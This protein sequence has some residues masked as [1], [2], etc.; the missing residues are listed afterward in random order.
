LKCLYCD[1]EGER[2]LCDHFN[3]LPSAV[4]CSN[5]SA[6]HASDCSLGQRSCPICQ[7][8]I[9]EDLLHHSECAAG[10]ARP[11]ET[12]GIRSSLAVSASGPDSASGAGSSSSAATTDT[13]HASA[14]DS[15]ASSTRT[16]GAPTVTFTANQRE[17]N[18]DRSVD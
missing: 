5:C 12:T 13:L 2:A 14:I 1:D 15:Q 10:S 8:P 7:Q 17:V 4:L 6:W 3:H 18:I 11:E 9:H 16:I